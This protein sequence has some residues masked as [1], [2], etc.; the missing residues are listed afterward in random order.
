[1]SSAAVVIG[2]L[3]VKQVDNSCMTNSVESDS[4]ESTLFA[5]TECLY[6]W[7]EHG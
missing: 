3:R 1:M 7:D 5:K 4:L 6:V 2:V